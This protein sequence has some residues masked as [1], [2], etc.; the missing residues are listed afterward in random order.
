MNILF[1]C[2]IKDHSQ[3]HLSD[4]STAIGSGM[5]R[6]VN[7]KHRKHLSKFISI[8]LRTALSLNGLNFE[9]LVH[10]YMIGSNSCC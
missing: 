5:F 9:V 6:L 10:I 2:Q 7:C 1:W 8:L 3:V 4:Y